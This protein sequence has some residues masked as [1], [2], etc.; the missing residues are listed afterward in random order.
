MPRP[1]PIGFCLRNLERAISTIAGQ[2]RGHALIQII[3]VCVRA[4]LPEATIA[5]SVGI[6][7]SGRDDQALGIDGLGGGFPGQIPYF[8]D[9]V[10]Y[11][12][13]IAWKPGISGTI[14][15]RSVP[16]EDVKI[17]SRIIGTPEKRQYPEYPRTGN[18]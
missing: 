10:P 8:D 12:A 9:G 4:G 16:D 11:D 17:S 7:E 14:Y 3:E 1:F 6:D 13:D 18:D 5:M 2:H 15:D